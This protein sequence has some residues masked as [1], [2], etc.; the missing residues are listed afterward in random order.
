MNEF[1]K[2]TWKPMQQEH[3]VHEGFSNMFWN[4]PN[5]LNLNMT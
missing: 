2:S 5:M 4:A 3:F 1:I